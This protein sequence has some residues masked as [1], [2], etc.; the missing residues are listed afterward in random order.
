MENPNINF[1]DYINW[2]GQDEATAQ[3]ERWNP[4]PLEQEVIAP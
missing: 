1:D 2:N 3:T 4:T